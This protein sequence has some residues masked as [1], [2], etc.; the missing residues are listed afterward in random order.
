MS[1][2]LSA[3]KSV[4]ETAASANSMVLNKISTLGSTIASGFAYIRW[5]LEEGSRLQLLEACQDEPLTD[6]SELT[7]LAIQMNIIILRSAEKRG[8]ER[9]MSFVSSA[10]KIVAET[11]A[12]ATGAVLATANSVG[13][14][15]AGDTASLG[16]MA[17][18]AAITAAT[19]LGVAAGTA[20]AVAGTTP[21]ALNVGVMRKGANLLGDHCR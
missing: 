17:G 10:L 14:V 18:S 21:I 12:A 15:I 11:A 8:K 6:N 7:L 13:A 3:L 20:A 9:V 4:A 16:A 2:V 19:T 1:F 5:L